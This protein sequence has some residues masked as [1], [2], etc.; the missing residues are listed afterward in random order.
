M[1]L[2]QIPRSIFKQAPPPLLMIRV[3]AF[4]ENKD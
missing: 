2:N 3:E 1:E 4:D